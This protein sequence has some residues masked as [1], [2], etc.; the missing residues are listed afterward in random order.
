MFTTIAIETLLALIV[1]FAGGLFW[2]LQKRARFLAEAIRSGP[3]LSQVISHEP[4]EKASPLIAPF[5]E[6]K[7]TYALNVQIVIDADNASQRRTKL[8]FVVVVAGAF[9]G[10]YFLGW[11][12]FII[13]TIVFLLSAL[14]PLSPSARS[15]AFQ[16]I[17]ALALILHRWRAENPQECDEWIQRVP[18]LGPIYSAVKL[19]R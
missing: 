9:I 5:A 3:L 4:L 11:L 18:S 7:L 15:N 19:A 13:T 16:H 1:F 10:S 17:L 2:Q 12:C 6:K 14:S 8:M